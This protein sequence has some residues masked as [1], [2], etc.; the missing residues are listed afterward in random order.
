MNFKLLIDTET[1]KQVPAGVFILHI[2]VKMPTL[3]GILTFMSKINNEQN[4]FHAQL[5][6]A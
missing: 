2:N 5:S 4:K 3:V 6:Q 1:L